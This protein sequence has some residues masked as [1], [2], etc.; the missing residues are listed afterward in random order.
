ML[1]A[2]RIRPMRQPGTLPQRVPTLA[3]ASSQ[4]GKLELQDFSDALEDTALQVSLTR[5]AVRVYQTG[6]MAV[7]DFLLNS[8][9]S[10]QPVAKK[11]SSFLK[12]LRN[13]ALRTGVAV[14]GPIGLAGLAGFLGYQ[15]SKELAEGIREKDP[16]AAIN[17]TRT[18]FLGA[19]SAAL[20][21]HTGGA[22]FNTA[23][24]SAAA[25]VAKAVALPLGI[26][27]I[28]IDLTQGA[29]ET[30]K[31]VKAKDGHA[32][33]DGL[34]TFGTGAAWATGLVAGPLVA[35][36]LAAAMIVAKSVNKRHAK[37]AAKKQ[38][39]E[40]EQPAPELLYLFDATGV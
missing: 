35:M 38:Q 14:A 19:E 16:D 8:V 5:R 10:L 34:A 18:M 13:L 12:G 20:A 31:A 28:G 9:S 21:A 7:N 26:I 25:G 36:P 17:G 30:A 37:K 6:E 27:H 3:E 29:V 1:D 40:L 4:L 24:T 39:Q 22:V 32:L 23:A 33:V 2:T 15:G 11:A